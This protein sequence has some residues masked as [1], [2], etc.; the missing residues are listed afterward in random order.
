MRMA[1]FPV[2]PALLLA[3][4]AWGC[5]SSAAS[6]DAARQAEAEPPAGVCESPLATLP[7][8]QIL[9]PVHASSPVPP[10]DGRRVGYACALVTIDEQGAVTEVV[11]LSTNNGA[12]AESFLRHLHAWRYE[13]YLVAGEAVVVRKVEK[14]IFWQH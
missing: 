14:A 11:L 1:V 10:R 5:G 6:I 12:F 13:P 8:D 4:L 3:L 2:L 7:E 9:K